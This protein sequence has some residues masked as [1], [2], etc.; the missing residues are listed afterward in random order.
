MVPCLSRRS[1]APCVGRR[2]VFRMAEQAYCTHVVQREYRIETQRCTPSNTWE[3]PPLLPSPTYLIFLSES[4]YNIDI[5][6]FPFIFPMFHLFPLFGLSCACWVLPHI[7]GFAVFD[8]PVN[9][10]HTTGFVRTP[11]PPPPRL[12]FPLP[13]RPQLKLSK[14]SIGRSPKPNL[15]KLCQQPDRPTNLLTNRLTDSLTHRPVD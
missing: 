14:S 6:V 2:A 3:L 8:S 9:Q 11:P 4:I 10:S 1:H 7:S 15:T 13:P 5:I 12:L